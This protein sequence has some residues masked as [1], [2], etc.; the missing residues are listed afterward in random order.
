[1]FHK[2]MF[3][4]PFLRR[5]P[6]SETSFSPGLGPLCLCPVEAVR[7]SCGVLLPHHLLGTSQWRLP[8]QLQGKCQ[9]EGSAAASADHILLILLRVRL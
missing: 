1:M 8:P 5:G 2:E 9:G 3:S 4:K 7:P 6:R